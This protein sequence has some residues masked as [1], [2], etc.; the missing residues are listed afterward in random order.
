MSKFTE[1]ASVLFDESD[2]EADF[3]AEKGSAEEDAA[4]LC[5]RSD[6]VTAREDLERLNSTAPTT[7]R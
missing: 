1:M 4:E 6:C 3:G 7:I 2:F 5:P